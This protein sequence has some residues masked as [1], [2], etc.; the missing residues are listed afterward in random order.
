[1][2][3]V[4]EQLYAVPLLSPVTVIGLEAPVA[5]RVVPPPVHDAVY[6]LIAAPPSDQGAVKA[7]V[8]LPLPAVAVPMVGAPGGVGVELPPPPPPPPQAAS[9]EKT[10]AISS[11]GSAESSLAIARDYRSGMSLSLG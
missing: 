11:A 7:T 5:V 3:A 8:A 1:L 9:V 2:V 10:R 4:T 6:P